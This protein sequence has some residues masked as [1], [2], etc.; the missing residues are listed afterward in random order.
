VI[1]TRSARSSIQQHTGF[2][3]AF[4]ALG[5]WCSW[6]FDPASLSFSAD[7][8]TFYFISERFAS[9]IPPHEGLVNH[10]LALSMMLSGGAIRIGRLLGV[11]DV[12]AARMLSVAFAAGMPALVYVLTLRLARNRAAALLA[13]AAMLTFSDFFKQGAMGVRPQLFATFFVT[14][15]LTLCAGRRHFLSGLSAGAAF[16]C[17]QP[18]AT[19][20]PAVAFAA[21]L[22]RR[23]LRAFSTVC[24]G[25]G[26][27]FLAYESYFLL[28]GLLGEQLYQSFAMGLD[29]TA[30]EGPRFHEALRFVLLLEEP[31]RTH[32]YLFAGALVVVLVFG[33]LALFFSR[34]EAWSRIRER[35]G[36][37]AAAVTLHLA[38]A[39]TFIDFQAFPDRFVLL[40][41][42]AAASG[43]VL[44]TL[45]TG[46]SRL[47]SELIRTVTVA[48]CFCLLVTPAARKHPS[49][50]EDSV[51]L[52]DQRKLASE[53]SDLERQYGP[54]WAIGCVHLLGLARRDNF[55]RYGVMID[56][57]IRAYM[58]RE[59]PA[60]ADGYRPRSGDGGM[61]GVVLTSRFGSRRALPWLKREYRPLENE[62]F[63]RQRITVWVRKNEKRVAEGRPPAATRRRSTTRR[64]ARS[65]AN[66]ARSPSA[67]P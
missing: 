49:R 15:A 35:P 41:F 56:P 39:F 37:V 32:R 36:L 4:F 47:P 19:V 55:D 2:A 14:L 20:A 45:I 18:A 52:A 13:G 21:L 23:P 27:A 9:G 67:T 1:T 8:Q 26:A 30:H 5:A 17:W 64:R 63:G 29:T 48:L 10:K 43:Y 7:N 12:S 57:R 58:Q 31:G 61:P 46:F 25:G 40:P 16:L 66:A 44:A 33:W 38:I 62:A 11:D 50:G 28:H 34:H 42:Y 65:A 3:L 59:T 60:G 6:V 53:I 54:V 22:D 24:V 51:S